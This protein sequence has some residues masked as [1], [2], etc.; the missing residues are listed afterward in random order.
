VAK[1]ALLAP[2]EEREVGVTPGAVVIGG[3]IAGMSA[4]LDVADAGFPVYLVEQDDHLGG[5]VADLNYVF[6][7]LEPVPE[8]LEPLIERIQT[9]PRITVFLNAQVAEVEG[10]VGNF[11]VKIGKLVDQEIGKLGNWE[12][13][14]PAEEACADQSTNLPTYQSTDVG[15]IIIATG[16]QPFD[17]RKIPEYGYGRFD[18]VYTRWRWSGW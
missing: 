18:K 4:A 11:T 16:Y 14:K 12:T 10:Y 13:G 7:T 17:A 5:R 9:H 15:S 6:P 8:L 2:L 3:G 1:V